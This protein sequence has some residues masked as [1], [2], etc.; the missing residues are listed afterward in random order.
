M[1]KKKVH[2]CC[3]VMCQNSHFSEKFIFLLNICYLFGRVTEGETEKFSICWF[4]S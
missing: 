3:G 2:L 1:K 4:T